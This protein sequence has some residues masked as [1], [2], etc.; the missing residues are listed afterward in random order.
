[1][2]LD[3]QSHP[4]WDKYI[5][6]EERLGDKSR[7]TKIYERLVHQIIWALQR[8]Y[9]KFRHCLT[10]RP[11]EELTDEA[12]LESAKAYVLEQAPGI[13]ERSEIEFDRAVRNRLDHIYYEINVTVN[14]EVHKRW[15]FETAIKRPY[16]HVTDNVP[17]EL[18]N[19]RNY[20]DFE[21]NEGDYKRIVA[22][23]ERCLVTCALHEEFW[24]RY[25]RWMFAQGKD[26]DTR[27]IY[28]RASCIFVPIA[29]PTIR[30]HWAR[31]E[32]KLGS[33]PMARDIHVGILDQLPDHV[34]TIISLA[35]LERRNEGIEA[36]VE[37]LEG[38]INQRDITIAGQ[39]TVEQARILWQCGGNVDRA[40]KL[41]AD[42]YVKY[43]GSE[44]FW[45]GYL[46][47]EMNQLPADQDEAH[48]RVKG[49]YDLMRSKGGFSESELK[50]LSQH[51]MNY[52]LD[53]GG[54]KA[55]EEYMRLD[56]ELN[57]YVLSATGVPPPI[58]STLPPTQDHLMLD[59]ELA[60]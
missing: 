13:L 50:A 9:A 47:F 31:F 17:E 16:F 10:E 52:L 20:L 54:K 7:L 38:Y 8:Y 29:Q 30:L 37:C 56:N 42:S 19:W 27:A 25:A 39:L 41:F 5:E 36:A 28:M 12:T 43:P 35:G 53:R 40:R 46:Q 23:Y 45:I 15:A 60:P 33:I 26:E 59:I 24:L 48:D 22:L 58:P 1:V 44:E 11:L 3:Y 4:F 49:V 6:F 2:G 21:E 14:A 18:E 57:G 32:E 34:E 51:Y 55:A